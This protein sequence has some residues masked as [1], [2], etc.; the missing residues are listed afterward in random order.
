MVLSIPYAFSFYPSLK[1]LLHPP[2]DIMRLLLVFN[3]TF[4]TDKKAFWTYSTS[5]YFS[6]DIIKSTIFLSNLDSTI[7]C[8]RVEKSF[9]DRFIHTADL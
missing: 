5:R 1:T 7:K 2:M 6:L 4:E 3:D 8:N 9:A